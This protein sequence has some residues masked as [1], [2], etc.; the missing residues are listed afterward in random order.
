MFSLGKIIINFLKTTVD[1]FS[2]RPDIIGMK[3]NE[4]KVY[5]IQ[6]TN[7]TLDSVFKTGELFSTKEKAISYMEQLK[8]DD[9]LPWNFEY[10]IVEEVLI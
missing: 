6:C 4:M 10:K 3:G 1:F 2:L 5:I 7:I 9:S 8:K